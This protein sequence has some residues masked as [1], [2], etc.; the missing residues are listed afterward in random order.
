MLGN[1]PRSKIAPRTPG[2][3]AGNP[4]Q[5]KSTGWG[6]VSQGDTQ[7]TAFGAKPR[8]LMVQRAL[9]PTIHPPLQ[10][11]ELHQ[12]GDR[13]SKWITSG[14]PTIHPL[15][16]INA[17][18]LGRTY[19][20]GPESAGRGA[21]LGQMEHNGTV[22]QRVIHRPISARL[23]AMLGGGFGGSP[24]TLLSHYKCLKQGKRRMA[25]TVAQQAVG[26]AE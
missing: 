13:T 2:W 10:L 6:R 18:A 7:L 17:T 19:P 11:K 4:P 9:S 8:G 25:A 20:A 3:F 16:Q 1:P 14:C 26:S 15:A 22:S 12:Y 21:F 23:R 24:M 5:P